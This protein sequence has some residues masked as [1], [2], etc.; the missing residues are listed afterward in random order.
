M[1]ERSLE[2][3]DRVNELTKSKVW[4]PPPRGWVKCNIEV[5]WDRN[6]QIGGGSWVLRDDRGRVVLHSRRAFS[7]IQNLHE[8]KLETLLW[9]IQSIKAHRY[10]RVIFAVD[11]CTLTKMILRPKA[12][13]NFKGQSSSIL[14]ELAKIEWWR[15]VKEDRST[16]RGAFLIAQ[17]VTKG[18]HCHSYV[19]TGRLIGCSP[20]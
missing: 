10:Y 2:E 12:W 9:S 1:H 15:L 8:A 11:D 6:G 14:E 3:E 18:G 13:P 17:S 5:D 7:H 19:A 20:I 16:N 4:T